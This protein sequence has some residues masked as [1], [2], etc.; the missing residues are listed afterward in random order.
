MLKVK[1]LIVTWNVNITITIFCFKVLYYKKLHTWHSL[2]GPKK[3]DI[4]GSYSFKTRLICYPEIQK[5]TFGIK[6]LQMED[7]TGKNLNINK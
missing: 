1:L 4:K 6:T 7:Y 5:I 3:T 2:N